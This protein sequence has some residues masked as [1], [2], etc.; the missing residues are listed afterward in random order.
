MNVGLSEVLIA[1]TSWHLA[2]SGH[3]ELTEMPL[4]EV[5]QQCCLRQPWCRKARMMG[6]TEASP[7]W[8]R[9]W[10]GGDGSRVE[11]SHVTEVEK[12]WMERREAFR[13]EEGK[14]SEQ[15]KNGRLV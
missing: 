14:G 10:G 1:A 15:E 9:R 6:R 3:H 12:R 13:V 11:P 7:Q 2:E 8:A 5:F 4:S